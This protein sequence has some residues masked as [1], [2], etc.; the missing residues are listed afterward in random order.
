M[1]MKTGKKDRKAKKL[2]QKR[3]KL[4][5]KDF[6]ETQKTRKQKS[7]KFDTKK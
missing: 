7:F 1:M 4:H 5:K 2:L 3:S 6:G